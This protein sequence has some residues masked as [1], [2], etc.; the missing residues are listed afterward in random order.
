LQRQSY[1]RTGRCS[2]IRGP[3]RCVELVFGNHLVAQ[4]RLGNARISLRLGLGVNGSG[5]E[6]VGVVVGFAVGNEG[7][8]VKRGEGT[9]VAGRVEG[10]VEAEEGSSFGDDV[11]GS[12]EAMEKA[13]VG[14]L[15]P[16]QYCIAQ[17]AV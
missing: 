14:T 2:C 13:S 4:T 5:L 11:N 16:S 15:Y 8:S 1:R 10:C 7:A 3:H 12:Y 6:G 17:L 9:L